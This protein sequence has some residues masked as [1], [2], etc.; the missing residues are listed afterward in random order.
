[1]TSGAGQEVRGKRSV[2]GLLP[3]ATRLVPQASSCAALGI[4]FFGLLQLD[5]PIVRYLRTVTSHRAGEQLTIPWMAFTSDAGDWI[6]EGSHLIA[7]SL[8][9]LAVGWI[10]SRATLKA[11]GVE[12]L[13]AHG[14]AA[15]LSNALKHLIGRPRPKFVHSGEWQFTPTWASGLDSFPSGHTTATFAV[16]TVLAKRC[17]SLGVPIIG[18]ALFVGVSRILRGSHFPTDV[19]GGAVLGVVSGS[20]AS[21]PWKD[22]RHS[23]EAGLRHAAIGTTAVFA[24][25]WSLARP[26]DTSVTGILLMG[27]GLISLVSGLWLRRRKWRSPSAHESLWEGPASLPC[28]V[29]G[30]ACMTTAPIVIAAAGFA[31]LAYGAHALPA[32]PAEPAASPFKKAM[33]ETGLIAGLLLALAILFEGRGVMPFQ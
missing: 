16:A 12:T 20:L 30:L 8:M 33:K 26:A 31:G 23:L 9:L 3:L 19:F 13:V 25:L 2:S 17:P 5:L 1:M 27:L 29:Y 28:I 6:G 4:V 11:A 15:L 32:Q 24:V 22:W 7:V 10:L 14:L 21:A 18:V